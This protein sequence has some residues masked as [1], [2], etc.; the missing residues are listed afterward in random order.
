MQLVLASI[1]HGLVPQP[2][3]IATNLRK[4]SLIGYI[5]NRTIQKKKL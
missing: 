3:G 5:E 1:F 2:S 4:K